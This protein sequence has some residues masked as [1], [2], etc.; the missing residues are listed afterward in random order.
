MIAVSVGFV[1]GKATSTRQPSI[2][3]AILDFD[4]GVF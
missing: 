2:Y 1:I 3:K 4:I